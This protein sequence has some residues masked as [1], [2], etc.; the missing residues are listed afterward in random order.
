VIRFNDQSVSSLNYLRFSLEK[1]GYVKDSYAIIPYNK[2]S[3]LVFDFS[4][5]D[6]ILDCETYSTRNGTIFGGDNLSKNLNDYTLKGK[7]VLYTSCMNLWLIGD[8]YG[9]IIDPLIKQNFKDNL[10]ITG[11]KNEWNPWWIWNGQTA[12]ADTI[13]ILGIK[14]NFTENKDFNINEYDP[15]NYIYDAWLD[16]I[17]I[18]DTNKAKPI[19]LFNNSKIPTNG[20][21]AAVKI[22]RSNPN[23]R[24]I[25]QGFSLNAIKNEVVRTT[26]LNNYIAW[27]LGFT[28][29][30]DLGNL[31]NA[32][33]KIYPNPCKDFVTLEFN[34]DVLTPVNF[35]IYSLSGE[36]IQEYE[37]LNSS[38]QGQIKLDLSKLHVGDYFI[39]ITSGGLR[40][41]TKFSLM[42]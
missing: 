8:N 37:Q 9:N 2:Q 24:A 42:R 33:L 41:I 17:N 31:N 6:I 12:R 11:V 27:L 14:G 35:E 28:S 36:L 40:S 3:G 22:E 4:K 25:Y 23:A 15:V 30:D 1:I 38:S 34:L 10:G 20:K 7:P 16:M 21:I 39:S 18:L 26:L 13:N 32:D 29:V 19:L 5:F